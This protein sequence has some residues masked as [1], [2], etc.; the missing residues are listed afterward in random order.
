MD[1]K[2]FSPLI[3][4]LMITRRCNYKC[5]FCIATK[6]L[7][8]KEDG[9]PH[10]YNDYEANP[11]SFKRILNHP[12]TRKILAIHFIGGEPTL[13]KYLPSFV[14]ETRNRGH[15]AVMT[16]NAISFRNLELVKN[17]V[18]AGINRITVS[19]YEQSLDAL[20]EI[21]PP[22]NKIIKVNTSLVL[23]KT[24]ITEQPQLLWN[25]LKLVESSGCADIFINTC[26]D[27]ANEGESTELI[28]DDNEAFY[29]LKRET[30][31]MF[32]KLAIIWGL[33][34][35]KKVTRERRWCSLLWNGIIMDMKGNM[36][37]CCAVYPNPDHPYG[38]F[39]DV[40]PNTLLN[41]PLTVAMRRTLLDQKT[42]LH[43]RCATCSYLGNAWLSKR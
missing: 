8:V 18:A 14:R 37:Q 25:S 32:P 23:T 6:Q 42:H 29:K 19:L 35:A 20:Y 7:G 13:N 17:L 2:K 11:E 3:L 15:I 38:N 24:I 12:I 36:G 33:P 43:K 4:H 22:V 5:S 39:F 26:T 9:I 30:G 10:T 1:I 27:A 28:Y 31:K 21:L 41:H 34:T 40:T 16:T